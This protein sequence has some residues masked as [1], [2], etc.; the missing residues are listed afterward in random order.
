MKKS[1]LGEKDLELKEEIENLNSQL[2]NMVKN[3]DTENDDLIKNI[4]II[5]NQIKQ[6]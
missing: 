4:E 3:K 5:R 1:V 6:H 2:E